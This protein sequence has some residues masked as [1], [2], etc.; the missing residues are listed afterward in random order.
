MCVQEFTFFS[1]EMDLLVELIACMHACVC[2]HV[3]VLSQT[4]Q[5]KRNNFKLKIFQ[6]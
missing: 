6:V 5:Q 4:K 3:A 2:V 1:L